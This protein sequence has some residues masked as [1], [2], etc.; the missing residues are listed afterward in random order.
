MSFSTEPTGEK[1]QTH[2]GESAQDQLDPDA[3]EDDPLALG[4][5]F[6]EEDVRG[7]R[8]EGRSEIDEQEAHLVNVAAEMLAGEAVAEFVD[9]AEDHEE[10]PEHPDVVGAFVG[11]IIEGGGVLLDA[12]PI[13]GEQIAGGDE[14]ADGEDD[15]A[16][17]EHPAEV[18]IDL[19]EGFVRVPGFEGHIE[20]A[21]LVDAA[22]ALV[23]DAFE[24][25]EIF[26]ADGAFPHGGLDAVEEFEDFGFAEGG[27]G[28][29]LGEGVG[30]FEGGAGAVAEF[31]DA[32]FGGA[33]TIVG[34]GFEIFYDVAGFAGDGLFADAEV[35]AEFGAAQ[36]FGEDAGDLQA[37]GAEAHRGLVYGC[38]GG[39]EFRFAGG[40][41][42]AAGATGAAAAWALGQRTFTAMPG[43]RS[44]M[45]E[46]VSW[47]TTS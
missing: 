25:G 9:A 14:N 35:G 13:G 19:G 24:D 23:A 2:A 22:F 27:I 33:V 45:L 39:F 6:E 18:G 8:I 26:F 1:Y 38:D 46:P 44:E 4:T 41:G 5:A 11:E 12:R 34:I 37:G 31:E 10:N 20:D 16:G 7:V 17:G 36:A 42:C 32:V 29:A 15:E 3:G 21:G 47:A 28:M 40:A 43:R 30:N